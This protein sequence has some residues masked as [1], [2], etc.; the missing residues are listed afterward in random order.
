MIAIHKG[1][2]PD[3]LA[4][5]RRETIE[6]HLSPE[7]A[8]KELDKYKNRGLKRRLRESLVREQ[9]QLCAYCMCQIPRGDV[10][11]KIP[12]II[13]EH[14][15]ARNPADQQDCNQGLDYNNLVAVCH[16]NQAERGCHP[17]GDLTCDAH[18]KTRNFIK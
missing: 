8:Y 18:K 7:D 3:G 1:A 11:E 12:P 9:G 2:E 10:P 16:G 14:V 5:L 13:I 4:E 15:M 17:Y 6:A